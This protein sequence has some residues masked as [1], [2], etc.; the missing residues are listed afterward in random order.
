MV[1]ISRVEEPTSSERRSQRAILTA[2][3]S[4]ADCCQTNQLGS[5]L[6]Q[7]TYGEAP[8]NYCLGLRQEFAERDKGIGVETHR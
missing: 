1:G 8:T 6:M 4:L 5:S 3:P 2:Y 7:K